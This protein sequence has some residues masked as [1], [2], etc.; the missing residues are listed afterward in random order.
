[1]ATLA[2]TNRSVTSTGANGSNG[3]GLVNGLA[4]SSNVPR[5]NNGRVG[6]GSAVDSTRSGDHGKVLDQRSCKTPPSTYNYNNHFSKMVGEASSGPWKVPSPAR[7][8]SNRRF[9]HTRQNRQKTSADREASRQP[10]HGAVPRDGSNVAR[11]SRQVS[12]S[13]GVA[14]AVMEKPQPLLRVRMG[15]RGVRS[16]ITTV[17]KFTGNNGK[18]SSTGRRRSETQLPSTATAV[19]EGEFK[20]QERKV[21][22]FNLLRIGGI[23][24]RG[25]RNRW[26]ARVAREAVELASRTA[27]L[28]V[29]NVD[30]IPA[31]TE[32]MLDLGDTYEDFLDQALLDLETE[33]RYATSA[34]STSTAL[35]E[36][37]LISMT[38]DAAHDVSRQATE[39]MS[40]LSLVGQML[41][42][43]TTQISMAVQALRGGS[44]LAVPS[45]QIETYVIET[46]FFPII[47]P[48][49]W[50]P[51]SAASVAGT[52]AAARTATLE[53][54]VA[55]QD[56]IATSTAEATPLQI[57]AATM[58]LLPTKDEA[59]L[60]GYEFY[61]PD[62]VGRLAETG[63]KM[64]LGDTNEYVH[65]T[66]DKKTD[67]FLREFDATQD[68][69]GGSATSRRQ[70]WQQSL[71]D[72]HQVLVW[73]GKFKVKGYG[74]ELPIIKTTSI[75]DLSPKDLTELLMDSDKVKV[76]NKISLGRNDEKVFQTGIDTI[77]G[78]HGDG[79]SKIVRNLT[80]PPMV[81]S[82]L[83]FV[84][85]MHARRLRP[86]D[87]AFLGEDAE[88]D[89]YIVVSRAVI[90]GEHG[91]SDN[92][93]SSSNGE[94]L[95]RNEILL[96]ANL[97]RSVPGM[98]G[99][100]EFTSVTHAYS[101][102]LPL[103]LAKSAGLKGAVDF[104]RDI[105]ALP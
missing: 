52:S 19:V 70:R 23:I 34:S 50:E 88:A 84:T 38:S 61:S 42:E 18:R 17:T 58:P 91:S 56:D 30:L 75:I 99:R 11:S 44:A 36:L 37:W 68:E 25:R 27:T 63:L 32:D 5:R 6:N 4:S 53:I 39:K 9:Q 67:R 14:S 3:L 86:S 72:S 35:D 103:M 101:P 10:L 45:S 81:S 79:E 102:M 2:S 43:Q 26:D 22:N 40:P 49:S 73:S 54:S 15:V 104:V 98:P 74:A 82:L 89:G 96:G 80:K 105:R 87:A 13:R 47:L 71:V 33:E 7:R 48:K 76:Y 20:P 31:E 16:L 46:P 65:W 41:Y 28:S 59:A 78:P 55:L 29:E 57:A 21:N 64:T 62:A 85:C 90:G 100:T 83:E 12:S 1:M 97:L 77:G 8:A 69:G 24:N 60:S 66:C 94:K 92:R 93:S 95:V 51:P